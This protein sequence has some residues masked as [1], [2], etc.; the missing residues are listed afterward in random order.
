MLFFCLLLFHSLQEACDLLTCS[1]LEH[2]NDVGDHLL[3][4]LDVCE[5]IELVGTYV[6]AALDEVCSLEDRLL[7]SVCVELLDKF[8]RSVGYSGVQVRGL[9]VA[10]HENRG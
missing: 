3:A 5:S 7:Q 10:Y 8:G 9:V 1:L 2:E 6:C 4:R